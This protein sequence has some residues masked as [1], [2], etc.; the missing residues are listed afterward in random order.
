MFLPLVLL[1]LVALRNDLG[2]SFHALKLFLSVQTVFFRLFKHLILGAQN[3][4]IF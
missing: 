4:L 2:V 3:K 1:T